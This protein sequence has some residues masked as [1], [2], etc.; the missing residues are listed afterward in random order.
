MEDMPVWKLFVITYTK[1]II[2]FC[3]IFCAIIAVQIVST[4]KRRNMGLIVFKKIFDS[5]DGLT[6]LSNATEF[7][8]LVRNHLVTVSD[9]SADALVLIDVDN[10]GV[11]NEN[12]GTV[13]GDEKIKV[14]AEYTK[15]FFRRSDI[16]SRFES[17]MFAVYLKNILSEKML[18]KK[19][20]DYIENN[21]YLPA[22][23]GATMVNGR[24]NFSETLQRALE[25]VKISK[26]EG[27]ARFTVL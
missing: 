26:K 12:N 7:R 14:L 8:R 10:M 13:E 21:Y 9:L 11:F 27:R 15:N 18:Y 17:D 1:E 25:A 23:I 19:C 16:V 3:I 22:S 24:E 2:V 6:G 5:K 20:T 4:V